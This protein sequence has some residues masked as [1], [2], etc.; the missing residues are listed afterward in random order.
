[1]TENP[2]AQQRSTCNCK[3]AQRSKDFF[4]QIANS[5]VLDWRAVVFANSHLRSAHII[6]S[7]RSNLICKTH[8]S[9]SDHK[10]LKA[11]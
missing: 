7:R 4:V 2:A 9:N 1:M 6:A 3:V 10:Q 8:N 5:C 11:Y